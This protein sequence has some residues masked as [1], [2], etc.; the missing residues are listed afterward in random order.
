MFSKI[1][2][3]MITCEGIKKSGQRCINAGR[4]ENNGRFYC[5]VHDEAKKLN[6]QYM[7]KILTK[8]DYLNKWPVLNETAH[9]NYIPHENMSIYNDNMKIIYKS[10]YNDTIEISDKDLIYNMVFSTLPEDSEPQKTAEP[11][12]KTVELDR[13]CGDGESD[14]QCVVCMDAVPNV[15]FKP[16]R[17]MIC[18]SKCSDS[19]Q[20]NNNMCPACRSVIK[21]KYCVF[22]S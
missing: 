1:G 4:Y 16:C 21:K 22:L 3:K 12:Q 15:V 17:H 13:F 6:K 2:L 10:I 11:P 14:R 19:I 18:C 7:N 8:K 20:K 5:G 9:L